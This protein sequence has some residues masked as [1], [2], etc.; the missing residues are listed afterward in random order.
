MNDIRELCR[1]Y[2]D[3]P[4]VVGGYGMADLMGWTSTAGKI[5]FVGDSAYN[6]EY[7]QSIGV[8]NY[9]VGRSWFIS[10]SNLKFMS[11]IETLISLLVFPTSQWGYKAL[12][13]G[14]RYMDSE[15]DWMSEVKSLNLVDELFKRL[16][17]AIEI[18]EDDKTI[19]SGARYR[20]KLAD[21][22]PF[23]PSDMFIDK[24]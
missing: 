24:N 1:E 17:T 21:D 23:V 3:L 4:I 5:Q 2:R 20:L 18:G 7:F 16:N 22:N 8:N 13:N 19:L 6:N 15:V 10:G 11:N 14:I 12:C 9:F